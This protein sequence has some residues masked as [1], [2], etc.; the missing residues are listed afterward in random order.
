MTSSIVDPSRLEKINTDIKQVLDELHLKPDFIPQETLAEMANQMYKPNYQLNTTNRVSGHYLGNQVV[1]QADINFLLDT[2]TLLKHHLHKDQSVTDAQL[3][4]VDDSIS[5]IISHADAT[6]ALGITQSIKLKKQKVI[7]SI[8]AEAMSVHLPKSGFVLMEAR[9]DGVWLDYSTTLTPLGEDND[10][11]Y[12]LNHE[13][14]RQNVYIALDLIS[15]RGTHQQ[16]FY[17]HDAGKGYKLDIS[18]EAEFTP[19]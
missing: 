7:N 13:L 1:I 18:V 10:P 11:I 19:I 16:D 9:L 2:K 4:K 3:E 8:E 6:R 17:W 5:E 14:F 12:L 15:Q